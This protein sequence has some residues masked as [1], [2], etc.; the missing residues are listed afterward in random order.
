MSAPVSNRD[1]EVRNGS[2]EGVGRCGRRQDRH[3]MCSQDVPPLDRR[4]RGD[5]WWE[6]P[7]GPIRLRVDPSIE[8]SVF[9]IRF[10]L[11]W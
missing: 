4:A 5:T 6:G 9:S 11:K 1:R 2:M 8:R 10:G 7:R 3:P